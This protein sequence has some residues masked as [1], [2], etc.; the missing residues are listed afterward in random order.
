[1]SSGASSIQTD[2]ASARSARSIFTTASGGSIV[3]SG[4]SGGAV[5]RERR[6]W[7]SSVAAAN[8]LA[9]TL[10]AS[11][12]MPTLVW[13]C[14]DDK[15]GSTLPASM[16][17]LKPARNTEFLQAW[18]WHP[19]LYHRIWSHPER[20]Q[21]CCRGGRKRLHILSSVLGVGGLNGYAPWFTLQVERLWRQVPDF[22]RSQ[23]GLNGQPV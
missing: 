20:L 2:R 21:L 18:P 16:A 9:N 5:G 15:N 22:A 10:L 23:S 13:A 11:G 6:V 7:L 4:E 1:M 17:T 8:S 12:A 3:N 19:A 14:W